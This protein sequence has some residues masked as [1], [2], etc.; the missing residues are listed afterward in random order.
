MDEINQLDNSLNLKK[1]KSI[2]IKQDEPDTVYNNRFSL[3]Q[4][5]N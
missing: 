4:I 5:I 2:D 1:K 3:D